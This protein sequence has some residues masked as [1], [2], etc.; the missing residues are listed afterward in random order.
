VYFFYDKTDRF[1]DKPKMKYNMN[2][3]YF[4]IKIITFEY[5]YGLFLYILLFC[6]VL[7]IKLPINNVFINL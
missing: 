5:F 7:K 4:L 1:F 2:N 3:A 6:N